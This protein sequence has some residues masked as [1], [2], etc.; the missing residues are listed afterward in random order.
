MK[1]PM[2]AATQNASVMMHVDQRST[3]LPSTGSVPS[4]FS[5]AEHLTFSTKVSG[6]NC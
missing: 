3:Q 1:H 6:E 2:T 5:Q 4:G